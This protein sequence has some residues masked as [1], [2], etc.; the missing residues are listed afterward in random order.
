VTAHTGELQVREFAREQDPTVEIFLDLDVPYEMRSWFELAV[1]CGAYL[2]WET[3][4]RGACVSFRTQ[5]FFFETPAEGDI[6]VILRYLA[7][8]EPLRSRSVPAPD[9]DD[10]IQVVLSAAPSRLAQAGWH[11]AYL[12]DPGALGADTPTSPEA[13]LEPVVSSITVIEKVSTETPAPIT[14]LDSPKLQRIPGV[15]LDDRLRMVPG[16]S[17]F[18][19]N[20]SLVAHP[21]TQGLSLRGIG[22]SGASRTLVLW[23]GIPINDPFGGWVYWTRVA[24]EELGRVELSRGASTSLFGDRAMGGRGRF[25]HA[26]AGEG[27]R[28]GVVRIRQPEYS[29]RERRRFEY[30]E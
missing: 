24:P 6:Y 14:L 7:L 21:T 10:N 11:R 12:V 28:D 27:T 29:C 8:V 4:A 16:F 2:A 23:D 1:D 5:N 18:R 30:L 26:R 25:V 9:R 19:R 20:S 3:A 13:K 17:L 22:S 15:N